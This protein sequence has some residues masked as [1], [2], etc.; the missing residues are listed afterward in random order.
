M[1]NN[2][3]LLFSILALNFNL[4]NFQS[5]GVF[6]SNVQYGGAVVASAFLSTQTLCCQYCLSFANCQAWTYNVATQLCT[7]NTN[8]GTRAA[9]NTSKLITSYST[10]L[11]K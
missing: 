7:A 4:Y 5:C 11:L 10:L 3:I 6:E 2:I 9:S 8:I 1:Q